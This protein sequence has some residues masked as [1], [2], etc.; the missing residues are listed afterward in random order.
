MGLPSVWG[1]SGQVSGW[2]HYLGQQP[3]GAES[4]SLV[5]DRGEKYGLDVII[6]FTDPI[7]S[8]RETGA[9]VIWPHGAWQQGGGLGGDP[10]EL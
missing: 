4:G 5:S 9:G 3:A 2:G 10:G 7:S 8:S 6:P 1:Q